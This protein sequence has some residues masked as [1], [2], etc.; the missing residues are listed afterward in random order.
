MLQHKKAA[1]EKSRRK[2]GVKLRANF[3]NEKIE[4]IPKRI[5]GSWFITSFKTH[6]E[7]RMKKQ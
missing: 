1:S 7:C 2:R 6:L 3:G 4:K 5:N